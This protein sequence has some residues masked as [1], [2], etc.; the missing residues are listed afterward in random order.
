ME[1]LDDFKGREQR[2]SEQETQV[3][4]QLETERTNLKELNRRLDA[5]ETEMMVTGK[6]EEPWGRIKRWRLA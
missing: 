4:A 5:L 1:A 3:S 2:L 6:T